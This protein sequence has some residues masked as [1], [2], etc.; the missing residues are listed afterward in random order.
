L[1]CKGK[2]RFIISKNFSG[3]FEKN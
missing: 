1:G 2:Q 3:F